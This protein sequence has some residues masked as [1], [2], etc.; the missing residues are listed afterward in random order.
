MI[1]AF[2]SY[3]IRKPEYIQEIRQRLKHKGWDLQREVLT[4]ICQQ[5]YDVKDVN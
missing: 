3:I 2:I 1:Y 4:L 5:V